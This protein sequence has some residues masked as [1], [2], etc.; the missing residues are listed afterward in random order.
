MSSYQQYYVPE[1]S[2]FP[3]F[4]AISLF[5]M[6]MG[7]AQQSMHWETLKVMRYIFSIQG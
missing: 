5:L 4:A 3:I 7:A 2:R 1:Q 6:V